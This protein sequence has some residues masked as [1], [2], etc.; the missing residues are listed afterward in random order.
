MCAAYANHGLSSCPLGLLAMLLAAPVS[1]LSAAR[2]SAPSAPRVST[3]ATRRRPPACAARPVRSRAPRARFCVRPA[4][5]ASLRSTTARRSACRARKAGM[6]GTR[7]IRGVS[8]APAPASRTT[9]ASASVPPGNILMLHCCACPSFVCIGR[10]VVHV[11]DW[12]SLASLCFA[13]AQRWQRVPAA[14]QERRLQMC[15]RSLLSAAGACIAC[16]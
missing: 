10:P 8:R 4:S 16:A 5:P 15:V 1:S 7:A 14:A 11:A 3:R 6:A 9:R 12:C 13:A 2:S